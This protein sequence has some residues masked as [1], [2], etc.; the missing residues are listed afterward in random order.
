MAE[1]SAPDSTL[2]KLYN[3]FPILAQKK[4]CL[5]ERAFTSSAQTIGEIVSPKKVGAFGT[6][7]ESL[8]LRL[9]S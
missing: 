2:N 5:T 4:I 3:A 7:P 6:R 8:F 1:T 9:I